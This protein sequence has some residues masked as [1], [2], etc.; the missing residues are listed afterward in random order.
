MIFQLHVHVWHYNNDIV[1]LRDI[2][3]WKVF[4][5]ESLDVSGNRYSYKINSFNN[6]DKL[7]IYIAWWICAFHFQLSS[8]NKYDYVC[9]PWQLDLVFDFM[10]IYSYI[11]FIIINQVSIVYFE[12]IVYLHIYKCYFNDKQQVTLLFGNV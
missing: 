11:H 12:F 5:T 4:F 9:E 7:I 3:S 1:L 6:C 2:F 8:E 10:S